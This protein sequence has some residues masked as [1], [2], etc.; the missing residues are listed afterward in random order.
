MTSKLVH[1]EKFRTR[2]HNQTLNIFRPQS[3]LS[4]SLCAC[5]HSW[6]H[7]DFG[8]AGTAF[9]FSHW[10]SGAAV[11]LVVIRSHLLSRL[12]LAGVLSLF[13]LCLSVC[14]GGPV[15]CLHLSLAV[16]HSD[17]P[18]SLSPPACPFNANHLPDTAAEHRGLLLHSPTSTSVYKPTVKLR[19]PSTDSVS[20]KNTN[21]TA[22][23]YSNP[24]K[25]R[26]R[27]TNWIWFSLIW[28]VFVFLHGWCSLGPNE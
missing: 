25:C 12:C 4:A 22:R 6:Q 9:V 5:K 21:G 23:D 13:W 19:P 8:A 7:L 14:G 17:Y 10:T 26:P 24:K 16:T 15:S 2:A 28:F 20:A 1:R 11:R 27:W 18:G 3:A